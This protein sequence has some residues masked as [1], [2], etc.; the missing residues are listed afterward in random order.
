[1]GVGDLCVWVC[2]SWGGSMSLRN[3]YTS[4]M[5]MCWEDGSSGVCVR[6]CV[7]VLIGNVFLN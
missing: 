2:E 1:M 4:D 6:I 7:L 5:E 3:T